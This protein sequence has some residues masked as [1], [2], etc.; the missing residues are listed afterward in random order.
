MKGRKA[1][2]GQLIQ[3]PIR[4]SA[5]G[6]QRYDKMTNYIIRGESKKRARGKKKSSTMEFLPEPQGLVDTPK[7]ERKLP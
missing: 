6:F 1:D 4:N 7:M 2:R 5:Q 3:G